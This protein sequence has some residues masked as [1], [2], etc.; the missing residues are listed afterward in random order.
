[1][2]A[3]RQPVTAKLESTA[4]GD[5]AGDADD[6]GLS[7]TTVV[8][9]DGVA[10]DDDEPELDDDEPE[11]DDDGWVLEPAPP[12]DEDVDGDV[13]DEVGATDEVVYEA[14]LAE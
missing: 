3:L 6:V 2:A 13:A 9:S 1:M 5:A 14:P 4:D 10:C 8:D 12:A 11:P 7:G